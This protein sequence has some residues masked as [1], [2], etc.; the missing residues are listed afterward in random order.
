M[1]ESLEELSFSNLYQKLT[2]LC[3][4]IISKYKLLILIGV[5]GSIFGF[6]Y[7]KFIV[8]PKYTG[9][10]TFVLSNDSKT[11][12]LGALAGNFGIELGGG[13]EGAFAGE[14]IIQLLESRKMVERAIFKTPPNSKISLL[15]EILVKSKPGQKWSKNSYINKQLPFPNSAKT[16]T[17]VQDSLFAYLHFYIVTN[18]LSVARVD[19]KLSFYKITTTSPSENFSRYL[20]KFL[21]DEAA[22]FYIE[23][24]TKQ[25]R[26]NLD[27]LQSEADSLR[28]V[29]G[30]AITNLATGSDEIFNLNPS[31]QKA[32]IQT[33][34][35]QIQTQVLGTAYAEVVKNLEI[36][37]ITLQKE[38][39]LYQLIDVPAAKLKKEKPSG[40]IYSIIFGLVS[41]MF[42]IVYLLITTS[43]ESRSHKD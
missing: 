36:A 14:N 24:K 7:A 10:L 22:Q 13:S 35:S 29:L 21:V 16:F 4:L 32:R 8:V 30:G 17:P 43:N 15:N 23:T 39:P 42:C 31:L 20:T 2:F 34:K 40:L 12:G 25:A 3:R 27:M 6:V 9:N 5:L 41:I 37:K 28:Y 18:Y 38:T 1:Q 26:K 19:K 11:S 33:Q